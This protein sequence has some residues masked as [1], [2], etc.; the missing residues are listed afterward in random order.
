MLV[1]TAQETS[2]IRSHVTF[3]IWLDLDCSV[4]DFE[5]LLKELS[6]PVEGV[7]WVDVCHNVS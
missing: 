6:N 2:S 7:T 5:L 1:D 3:L 4:V